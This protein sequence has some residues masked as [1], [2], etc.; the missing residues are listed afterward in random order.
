M[1]CTNRTKCNH[2]YQNL[3]SSKT[4]TIDYQMSI[5][6]DVIAALK[7]EY[8]YL[9]K[10]YGLTQ[11]RL[12]GSVARGEDTENSDID[13]LYTFEPG[14]ATYDNLFELPEYLETLFG[15]KVDLVSE[16]WSGERFL[17]CALTDAVIF[18]VAGEVI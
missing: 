17:A 10:R 11:L 5:Q 3:I 7:R 6:Q 13:L 15:R 4:N 8:P 16:R 14:M 12:F 18:G 1:D 2:T 9:K